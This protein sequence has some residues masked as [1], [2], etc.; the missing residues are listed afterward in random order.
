MVRPSDCSRV[1]LQG[2][3]IY[4]LFKRGDGGRVITLLSCANIIF[5]PPTFNRTINPLCYGPVIV[6][7]LQHLA[8][9]Y[10]KINSQ[11]IGVEKNNPQIAEFNNPKRCYTPEGPFSYIESHGE[12]TAATRKNCL[13]K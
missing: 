9:P 13:W 6:H 12:S 2:L 11:N 8:C 1:S 7:E 4:Y 3:V 5:L 10:Y